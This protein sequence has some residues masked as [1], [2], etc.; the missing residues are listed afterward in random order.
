MQG[1]IDEYHPIKGFHIQFFDNGDDE[2]FSTL[3]SAE[4]ESNDF[5]KTSRGNTKVGTINSK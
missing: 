3:N 4:I 5:V 1:I 2:W